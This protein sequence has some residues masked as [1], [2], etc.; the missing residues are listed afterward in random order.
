MNCD[1]PETEA[2]FIERVIDTITYGKA[3]PSAPNER[4]I[5]TIIKNAAIYFWNND[6]EAQETEWL[7]IR[8]SAFNTDL[9]KAKRRILLP[10]CVHAVANLQTTGRINGASAF[11]FASQT[12]GGNTILN[13]Y[14]G[15]SSG[16]MLYAV[17]RNYYA[18]FQRNFILKDIQYDFNSYTHH[19]TIMGRN[20][21]VDLV[22]EIF[23]NIPM[24][25][26][27]SMDRFFRYV[28]GQCKKAFTTIY[29][30]TDAKMLGGIGLTLSD[31]RADGNDEIKEVKDEIEKQ[32]QEADFFDEC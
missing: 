27:Y 29:S 11:A 25:G 3:I 24:E 26:L 15:A 9:F 22:A 1:N 31:L 16:D 32:R 10:S 30:L 7:V 6:D 12:S 17:A 28:C 4:A 13:S 23:V 8:A 20:T 14:L 5:K 19:L 18:D 2:S 21:T